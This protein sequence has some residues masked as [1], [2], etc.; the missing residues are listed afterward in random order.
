MCQTNQ[1]LFLDHI[2]SS[3]KINKI[4][5]RFC[6]TLFN[7]NFSLYFLGTINKHKQLSTLDI[8]QPY[9]ESF[10]FQENMLAKHITVVVE[11]GDKLLCLDSINTI[12]IIEIMC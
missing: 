2:I 5:H 6:F 12:M 10:W 7:S 4:N 3:N 8:C 1:I 9:L 11:C